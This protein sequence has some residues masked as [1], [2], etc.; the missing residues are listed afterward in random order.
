MLQEV[1]D[2]PR[3]S[4]K[5]VA[6][7]LPENAIGGSDDE[8]YLLDSQKTEGKAALL[9]ACPQTGVQQVGLLA[10]FSNEDVLG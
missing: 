7:S 1:I 2:H 10:E 4:P 3:S 8:G 9:G 5:L 6:P